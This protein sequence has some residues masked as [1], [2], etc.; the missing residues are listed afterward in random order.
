MNKR[1][2]KKH[3][4]TKPKNVTFTNL[5]DNAD[6][7]NFCRKYFSSIKPEDMPM[8]LAGMKIP[9]MFIRIID[10]SHLNEH[11]DPVIGVIPIPC[12]LV[13]GKETKRAFKKQWNMFLRQIS[14]ALKKYNLHDYAVQQVIL[15]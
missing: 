13:G 5:I 6:S 8:I 12:R 11:K 14:N 7:F 1:I 2:K 15:K 10:I 3:I 9:C 4:F